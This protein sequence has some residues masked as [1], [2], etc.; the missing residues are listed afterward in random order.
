M[1]NVK[2][3]VNGEAMRGGRLAP[4]LAQARFLGEAS[5]AP[6]YRFLSVRDEYPALLPAG[7]GGWPVRGE[8]YEVAYA[9]LRD[10]LLPYEP[11]E[12]ELTI[13]E[14]ADGTGSLCMRL[15]PDRRDLPGLV[16]ISVIGS[17]RD[18]LARAGQAST[19][20]VG[21]AGETR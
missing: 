4:N 17:W 21:A 8:L 3:F 14:L 13:I 18:Y 6:V 1:E 20:Q 12:L 9:D 5:T 10:K 2:M 19:G 11:A 7:T 15:R 16:D